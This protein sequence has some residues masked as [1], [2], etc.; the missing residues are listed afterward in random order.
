LLPNQ[1]QQKQLNKDTEPENKIF[2]D[3]IL[4][5]SGSEDAFIFRYGT[6][7]S[8]KYYPRIYC[9][10]TRQIYKKGL[11]LANKEEA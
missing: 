11:G 3:K 1:E 7:K 2:Q 8:K 5:H 6:T 4:M 10:G 9:R